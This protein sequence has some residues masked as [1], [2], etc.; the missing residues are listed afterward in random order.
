MAANQGLLRRITARP[1]VLGGKPIVR[2]LR[3]SVELLL[4]LLAQG[5]APEEILD[6]YP[7]LEQ[8]D[9]CTCAAYAHAV[10]ARRLLAT[11][12]RRIV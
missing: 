3:I 4:S 5:V 2:D 7:G 8:D 1:D 12:R 11:D 10:T 6:D 9:M